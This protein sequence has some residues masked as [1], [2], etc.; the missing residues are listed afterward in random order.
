MKITKQAVFGYRASI[1]ATFTNRMKINK[2]AVF[3]Y[4]TCERSECS[5]AENSAI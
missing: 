4:P 2:Q 5:K 1:E 3:R